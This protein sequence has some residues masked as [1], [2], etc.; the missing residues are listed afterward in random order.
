MGSTDIRIKYTEQNGKY[1][2]GQGLV[3]FALLLPILVLIIFGVLDLGRAF[4][5]QIALANAARVGARS[6]S[7]NKEMTVDQ[8][9]E[10]TRDELRT[11]GLDPA[12]VA[13]SVTCTGTPAFPPNCAKEQT[14][15]VEVTYPFQLTITWLFPQ[16][17]TFQ[18]A[19]EMM[20]P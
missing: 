10:A 13:V 8:I 20:T 1:R 12:Q 17:I 9:R 4:F 3:E 7:F 16:N 11:Y 6:Y 19:V 15:R 5:A 18:R 14:I 2:H